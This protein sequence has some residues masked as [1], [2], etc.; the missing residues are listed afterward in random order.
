LAWVTCRSPCNT[1]LW[2]LQGLLSNTPSESRSCSRICGESTWAS[3]LPEFLY[4]YR[5]LVS[6][7]PCVTNP[8]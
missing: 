2:H 7:L 4:V 1:L 3:T 8:F 5:K 6:S